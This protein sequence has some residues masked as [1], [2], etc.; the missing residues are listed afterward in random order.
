MLAHMVAGATPP[1]AALTTF[2]NLNTSMQMTA[3]LRLVLHIFFHSLCPYL[4]PSHLLFLTF[5]LRSQLQT[6]KVWE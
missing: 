4:P 6:V 5:L 2:V 1:L 3:G